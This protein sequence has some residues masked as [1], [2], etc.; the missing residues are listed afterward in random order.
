MPPCRPGYGGFSCLREGVDI[1]I[2]ENHQSGV[3][4]MHL[5]GHRHEDRHIR[6]WRK[7]HE[8]PESNRLPSVKNVQ[9]LADHYGVNAAWLLGQSENWS[10]RADI[11][12]IGEITG[13]NPEAVMALQELMKD[14][15]RRE[16]I[17]R[18]L[19]SE[20]FSRMV[21]TLQGLNNMKGSDDSANA[22]DYAES[23]S[24]NNDGEMELTLNERDYTDLKLWQAEKEISRLLERMAKEK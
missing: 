20:E 18:L 23:F 16:F 8:N 6:Q 13:L 17:N 24:R 2:R 7:R 9:K 19:A 1:N 10:S 12:Q 3:S 11:Q 21:C 14:E 15:K 4:G 22:V 5:K